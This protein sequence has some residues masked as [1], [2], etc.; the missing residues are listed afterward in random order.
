MT[1]IEFFRHY[2]STDPT[3]DLFVDVGF[4]Y[5]ISA[6]LQRRVWYG[7]LE[8]PVFANQYIVLVGDAGVGKGGV[9]GVV[10][11]MLSFFPRSA[12]ITDSNL[13]K[14]DIDTDAFDAK[15]HE[16]G[17]E[18]LYPKGPNASS[19]QAL[20]RDLAKS[21]KLVRCRELKHPLAHSS[22]H[23][24]LD[25]FTSMFKESA[26]ETVDFFLTCWM[27]KDYTHSTIGRGKDYIKNP[28]LS[29]IAGTTPERLR[30]LRKI[31]IVG[32]GLARRI[33]FVYAER[34]RFRAWD[35]PPRT[36][37]QKNSRKEILRWIRFLSSA[38][39]SVKYTPEAVKL[40]DEWYFGPN[41]TIN[42]SH[43]EIVR[44]YENT[45]AP[46]LHKM[47]LAMHFSEPRFWQPG[48]PPGEISAEAVSLAIKMLQRTELERHRVL[49]YSGRSQMAPVVAKLLNML[50]AQR[51][52]TRDTILA[53]MFTEFDNAAQLDELLNS[54]LQAGKI[55][56]QVAKDGFYKYYATA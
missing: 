50:K 43:D 36:A 53:S 20:A 1:N 5:M 56:Q 18:L 35:R 52:M 29:M 37:D 41:Y 40:I 22:M 23:V 28:C 51:G 30:E 38:A 4:Y 11:D 47:A 16:D 7:S 8:K 12:Q 34:E 6:A 2:M 42:K 17:V 39:G 21:T 26:Q 49:E 27:G 32:S 54:L 44:G 19:Y 9:T 10:D 25:E 46:H 13:I 14:T 55:K 33:I 48:R 3:P 45:K 31:S 24:V 15:G